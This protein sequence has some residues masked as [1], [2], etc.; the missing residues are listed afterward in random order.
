[1]QRRD[2][3]QLGSIFSIGIV[4]PNATKAASRLQVFNTGEALAALELNSFILIT[5][6]NKITIFNPRPEMGQGT[7]QSM[8]ALIAEE[9][10]VGMDQ[11]EIL[12]SNG[13][14]KHGSQSAG[15]STS[16][17][18]LWKP[19]REVGAAAREMLINAAAKRWEV[20][21]KDCYAERAK[22]YHR[23][24]G[25]SLLYGELVEDA[26]KLDIPK[27][28]KLKEQ[29]EFKI[30]GKAE[31]RS[32]IP[33][34]VNGKADFGIDTRVPNMLYAS[35]E[36]S[37][38]IQGKV[39]SF[40]DSEALK[41]KGVQKVVKVLRRL[42]NQTFEG[43]AVVATNSWAAMQGRK[44][45]KVTWGNGDFD[46][47]S[48]TTYYEE[49]YKKVKEKGV[50]YENPKEDTPK[51]GEVKAEK[52]LAKSPLGDVDAALNLSG[53]TMVE[54]VYETPFAA[55]A[56]IE[57]LN[58]T[59]WVQGDKVTIWCPVQGPDDVFNYINKMCGFEKEN[60]TVNLKYL[61]GSFG[62]KGYLD[63]VAEAVDLAKQVKH[64]VQILWTREDD[65][66]QGMYRPGLLSAMRGAVKEGKAIALEHNLIGASIQ[67]H[68]FR[69]D[70]TTKAD[71]WARE[72]ISGEDSPYTIPNRAEHFK[73]QD[74][75]TPLLWWRSVYG[76]T[77]GFGQECFIDELAH[78]AGKDPLQFR[79]DMLQ[80]KS[81]ARHLNV[82]NK[83]KEKANYHEKSTATQ[84]IGIAITRSFESICAYC[85]TVSKK[86]EGIQ[87][88]NVVVVLD[89]GMTVNP[90]TVKA[91]TEGNIVMALSAATKP[92]I[93][94][95]KG[96]T[97][98]S[99]FHQ[100]P[101]LRFNETPPM[102]IHILPSSEAPGGAG[103]PSLPPFTPALCNAI[104]NLTGKRIRKLPF[105]L[106]RGF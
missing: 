95:E 37:P 39:L 9:L 15:G 24:S 23:P 10:E 71:D 68:L 64:P 77:N 32:D 62:R 105:E 93:T 47:V 42:D 44:A 106:E 61:G 97:Q 49:A 69:N 101:L 11:I 104:F 12:R 38:V 17:R 3:I 40:D 83:L 46:E 63:F 4:L 81:A 21:E 7:T 88:D 67:Q 28:P 27:E 36:R 85:I 13:L 30:L 33:L 53:V 94:I 35:V 41:V 50:L 31:K 16:V 99:N 48:T 6:E 51:E 92:A 29:K 55:H 73:L 78:A 2:F 87:I 91:Q 8:P 89:C 14:A 18:Q 5:K 80:D 103:E 98:Q 1:M 74:I 70:Q 66:T 43:V 34:K 20:N 19:L 82:L 96:V 100:Y 57:P 90:N 79:I 22:V 102:S 59:A 72:A 58:A 45:L 56:P 25:K 65:M 75:E 54:G 60:I 76:S 26:A 86:G 84:G 52:I